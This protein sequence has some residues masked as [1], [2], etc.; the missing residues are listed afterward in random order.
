MITIILL[1]LALHLPSLIM[2]EHNKS[3]EGDINLRLKFPIPDFNN[4]FSPHLAQYEC[5]QQFIFRFENGK[6]SNS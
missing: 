5:N 2:I 4:Y 1:I 6:R 3:I